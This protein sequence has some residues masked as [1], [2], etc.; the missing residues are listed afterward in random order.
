MVPRRTGPAARGCGTAFIEAAQRAE[1]K[2]LVKFS[3]MGADSSASRTPASSRRNGQPL[4]EFRRAVHD[5]AAEFLSS[6]HS[7]LR[8]YYQDAGRFLLA[9]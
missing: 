6:K 4:A 3:G 1:L 7:L 9:A 8:R 2:H 5:L